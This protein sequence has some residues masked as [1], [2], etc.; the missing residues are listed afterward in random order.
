MSDQKNPLQMLFYWAEQQQSKPYL[1]QAV[2]GQ[3]R[4]YTFG[5]V[6]ASVRRMA[7]ALRAL[8]PA[9]SKVAI[10]GRNTAQWFMADQ[11]IA[12]AGMV[13]VGLYPKQ[14][15][16]HTRFILEHSE[17]RLVFVGPAPDMDEFMRSIPKGVK[18]VGFPYPE[19]PACDYKWDELLVKHEPQQDIPAAKADDLLT[20]VY[21]SGDRKSV[22]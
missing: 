22:V 19:V 9:G 14:S 13:S 2:D 10:S 5:E 1:F 3:W 20:L 6:A 11:A 21:T 17:T 12:M 8:L 4:S 18:T 15:E 16:V 7:T